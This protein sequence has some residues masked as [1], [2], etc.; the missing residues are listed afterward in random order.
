MGFSLLELVVAIVVV[1]LGAGVIYSY[2]EAIARSPEPAVREK[3]IVLGRALMEEILGKRW[4]EHTPPGG[5]VL[6]TGETSNGCSGTASTPGPDGGEARGSFD[7]VDDYD[8]LTE[9]G[10]FTDESGASVSLPGYARSASVCYIPSGSSNIT[11]TNPACVSGSTTDTKRIT[12]TVTIPTGES[13]S[14]VSVRCNL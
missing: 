8:G 14:F 3:G 11:S 13:F 10:S 4:D 7:D 2:I 9:T 5:G 1:S 6:C 12:V